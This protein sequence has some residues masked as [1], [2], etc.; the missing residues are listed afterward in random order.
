[1]TTSNQATHVTPQ[2]VVSSK[3]YR[4]LG[5]VCGRS[6]GSR[7]AFSTSTLVFAHCTPLTR[8]LNCKQTFRERADSET[9]RWASGKVEKPVE[10]VETTPLMET[11]EGGTRLSR[12]PPRAGWNLRP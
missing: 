4:D 3:Q 10:K 2:R 1:M 6:K 11:K 7:S 9:S 5:R 8:D 12:N